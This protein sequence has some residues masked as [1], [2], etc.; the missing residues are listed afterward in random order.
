MDRGF[1]IDAQGFERPVIDAFFDVRAL[2]DLID[3]L[4]FTQ[5]NQIHH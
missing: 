5:M 1:A 2:H 3:V 4:G